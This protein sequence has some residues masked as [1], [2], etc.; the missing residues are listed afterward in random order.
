MRVLCLRLAGSVA[1]ALCVM[2]GM[3]LATSS[4]G[5][6]SL[7][8][9]RVYELVSPAASGEEAN[10]YVSSA[11]ED[12]LGPFY[13]HG[14]TTSKPMQVAAD[15]NR[16]IYEGEPGSVGGD[17]VFGVGAGNAFLATRSPGGGWTSTNIQVPDQRIEYRAFSSDLSVGILESSYP[18][19]A[20]VTSPSLNLSYSHLMSSGVGGEYDPFFPGAPPNRSV[21]EYGQVYAGGNKGS[22]DVPV[23][24]H[25]LFEANDALTSNGVDGDSKE[26][27]LYDS[28]GGQPYAVNVL[29]D[30]KQAP[31][32]TFGSRAVHQEGNDFSNVISA[33]GSRIFWTALE[34][35]ETVRGTEFLPKGDLC[36][37][38]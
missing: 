31:D 14:V 33:D 27:N 21:E 22:S 3:G 38:E 17:G 19:A 8:D 1:L 13:E 11:G 5:A 32:A 29:P 35:V 30:G 16:V 2:P 18:L 10:V 15:G 24:S 37:G 20:S 6:V 34:T 4:A 28:V 9:G 26:N 25:V 7:P 23:F 12:A 36:P